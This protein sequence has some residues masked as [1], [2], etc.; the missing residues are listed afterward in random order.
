MVESDLAALLR[1]I[2]AEKSPER[3][4]RLAIELQAV[5]RSRHSGSSG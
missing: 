4:L 1:D 2:E 5:L 3:L